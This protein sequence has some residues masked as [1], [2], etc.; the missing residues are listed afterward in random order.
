MHS[1]SEV[2]VQSSLEVGI[3]FFPILFL[4]P[5]ELNT[6]KSRNDQEEEGICV[7]TRHADS[8]APTKA[9]YFLCLANLDLGI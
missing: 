3:S 5:I 8:T 7:N 2:V 1:L 6:E 4:T 9:L